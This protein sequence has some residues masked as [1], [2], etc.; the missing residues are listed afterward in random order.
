MLRFLSSLKLAVLLI[1]GIAVMSVLATVYPDANAFTSLPFRLLVAAFFLNLL[2]CTAK[3]LPGFFRQLRRTAADLGGIRENVHF[4]E[5]DNPHKKNH[6][7]TGKEEDLHRFLKKHHYR[8][9]TWSGDGEKKILAKKGIGGLAAPHLLH[10]SILVVIIGA[11]GYTFNVSGALMAY[12]DQEIPLPEKLRTVYGED[13]RVEVV[14][15]VTHYDEDGAVDNWVTHFN[16]YLN[17][18]LVA[19]NAETKVN[20][21]FQYDGLVIYQNSYGYQHLIEITGSPNAEENSAYS[22]PDN[23]AF[24]IAGLHA[25]LVNMGQGRNYLQITD[26]KEILIGQ[27]VAPNDRLEVVPGVF[28]DYYDHTAYTVLEMKT[29]RGIALVFSGFLL[30]TIASLLF[31]SG[32]YREMQIVLPQNSNKFYVRCYCKSAVVVEEMEEILEEAW[33]HSY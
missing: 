29:D 18:Q 2:L 9:S 16:L 22:M 32:R 14:D 6:C 23:K 13:S 8:V 26:E 28:L 30:A 10:V 20:A 4:Y 7:Y 33:T 11:L 15:F 3:L 17:G 25:I 5:N 21:P 31:C 1:A 19:E 27:F 24:N 12:V